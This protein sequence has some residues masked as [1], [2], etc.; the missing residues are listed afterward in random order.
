MPFE[1]NAQQQITQ[2]NTGQKFLQNLTL[3]QIIVMAGKLNPCFIDSERLS[4]LTYFYQKN[5]WGEQYIDALNRADFERQSSS[6]RYSQQ[7]G[8]DLQG[9]RCLYIVIGTDSGLLIQHVLRNGIGSG[10]NIVFIEPDEIYPMIL[11]NNKAALQKAIEETPDSPISLHCHT[12]WQQEIRRE[13]K[14]RILLDDTIR[15]VQSIACTND[16]QHIYL[17]L[18]LDVIKTISELRVQT[19]QSAGFRKFT[20]NQISN[21]ADSLQSLTDSED[22]GKNRCAMVI[23]SDS[24]KQSDMDWIQLNRQKLFV[25]ATPGSCQSLHKSDLIPDIVV[26][27]D[28]EGS[29][30]SIVYS[31][32][33]SGIPLIHTYYAAPAIVQQWP[34]E[35]LRI[36]SLLPWLDWQSDQAGY[37][38]CALGPF[39]SNTA[40]QVCQ[41][42]GFSTV[43]LCGVDFH[44]HAYQIQHND[45]PDYLLPTLGEAN[46]CTYQGDTVGTTIEQKYGARSLEILAATITSGKPKIFNVNRHAIRCDS[47]PLIDV[48]DIELSDCKPDISKLL[49]KDADFFNHL[50]NLSK[51]TH[52]ARNAVRQLRRY[53]K[54]ALGT[55]SKANQEA[56]DTSIQPY[57]SQLDKQRQ[58]I[59]DNQKRYLRALEYSSGYTS[60]RFVMEAISP[61]LDDQEAL[62][63]VRT[64]HANMDR[65]A[66]SLLK[67]LDK[68]QAR[69]ELRRAEYKPESNFI[70]LLSGWEQDQTPGRVLKLLT[71][72]N[73]STDVETY[74]SELVNSAAQQFI[75]A[76]ND[77]EAHESQ[78]D[79][80]HSI[81][82]WVKTLIHLHKQDDQLQLAAIQERLVDGQW[83]YTA[84]RS[85]IAGLLAQAS[86]N[87]TQARTCYKNVIDEC[88]DQLESTQTS[89]DDPGRLIEESLSRLSQVNIEL[90]NT[91]DA[92]ICLQILCE[93]LPQYTVSYATLLDLSN[94][95]VLASQLLYE[96]SKVYPAD[97]TAIGLLNK[98]DKAISPAEE[99][100]EE[101]RETIR[102]TLSAVLGQ[103]AA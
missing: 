53:C 42:L 18:Y 69:I 75:K 71:R 70:K 79:H 3:A 39:N 46:L 99:D 16:Y 13:L 91:E 47:V 96:Y 38:A 51:E 65:C 83:P 87:A 86:D 14:D 48:K 72:L 54:E 21:A 27:S 101:Y 80:D 95:S 62:R 89:V 73:N 77:I 93:F 24:S 43:L 37:D 59:S 52:K 1:N 57:L 15:V 84:L 22:F 12:L 66:A 31:R 17:P 103:S 100:S 30:P 40:T 44:S 33:W 34:G 50:D 35:T 63:S 74:E 49:S 32:S 102:D 2:G 20:E 11:E 92:L 26:C 7:I 28:T 60:P 58:K 61:N 41:H 10:S 4:D 55:I 97:T 90:G 98:I 19:R 76:S 25:A 56:S 5:Q 9:S 64:Y 88:N 45:Q 78:P 85:F 94:K 82:Q 81:K 29:V 23:A 8:I 68:L 6:Y 36:G 67:Q